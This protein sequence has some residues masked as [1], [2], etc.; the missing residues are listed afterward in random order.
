MADEVKSRQFSFP[1]PNAPQSRVFVHVTV[2]AHSL[3]IYVSSSSEGASPSSNMGSFI[4]AMPNVREN[5]PAHALYSSLTSPDQLREPASMPL[6][7][8]LFEELP[9]MDFATRLAKAIAKRAGKPT[10]VASS[11]ALSNV[12]KAHEAADDVVAFKAVIDGI[13]A[14]V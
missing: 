4:Y 10:Y 2:Y 13:M 9:T 14:A 7:T 1:L 11:A 3:L 8:P 12:G 6:S 5:A